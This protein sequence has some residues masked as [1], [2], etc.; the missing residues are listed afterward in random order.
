MLTACP[1]A[2][3]MHPTRR[4]KSSVEVL[5]YRPTCWQSSDNASFLADQAD[6]AGSL[7]AGD[8]TYDNVHKAIFGFNQGQ[9]RHLL[10][11]EVKVS[12]TNSLVCCVLATSN[13]NFQGAFSSI[14]LKSLSA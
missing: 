10:S 9:N 5:H 13:A 11:P 1:S 6:A 14:K 2:V 3:F 4:Q 7:A 8:V 12:Q